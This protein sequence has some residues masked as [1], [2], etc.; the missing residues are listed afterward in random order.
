MIFLALRIVCTISFSHL[1]RLVQMRTRRPRAAAAV[2]Y[3]VAAAA[4]AVWMAASGCDLR[5]E[6]GALGLL[7]GCTYIL[8]IVL[9]FR[10]MEESGVSVTGAV[11]QLALVLPIGVS[12][13]RFDERPSTW[14]WAGIAVTAIALPLLGLAS[15][16]R[17]SQARRGF[18]ASTLLLFFATGVS[19][20]IQ[21]EFAATR[22]RAEL[23]V[24]SAA[25]FATAAALSFPWLVRGGARSTGATASSH[26][27]SELSLGALLGTVNVLAL[28]FLILALAALPAVV[29]FP[30]SAAV[31]IVGNA[32][33]SWVFWKERPS[34]RGWLGIALAAVAVVLFHFE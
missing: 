2:N 21:K 8:C 24:Y 12:I 6:S 11:V 13:W 27:S 31:G 19:Q 29:V 5:V 7:A 3:L 32:L 34:R 20:V 9:M 23:P 18:S 22:P 1:L 15:A 16:V 26:S 4:S 14:Q 25:L 28:L 30:I 10:A 33:A 17:D